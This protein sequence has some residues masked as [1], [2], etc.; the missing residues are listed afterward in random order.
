MLP[1]FILLA[2]TNSLAIWLWL[3]ALNIKYWDFQYTLS[4]LIQI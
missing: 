2:L 3:S 4:V 1:L